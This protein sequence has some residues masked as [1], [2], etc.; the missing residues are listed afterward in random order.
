MRRRDPRPPL[1]AFENYIKGLIAESPAAQATFLETAVKLFPG[2]DRAE[3][4]LWGVRTDQDDHAAAL[5]AVRAV[6][7]ARRWR[8]GRAFS[9]ASRCSS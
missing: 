9:P 6:P 1:D 2:Y 3:L 8:A 4:A 5:A 7:A